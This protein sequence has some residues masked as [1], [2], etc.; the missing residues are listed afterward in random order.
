MYTVIHFRENL[1]QSTLLDAVQKLV[2]K[3]NT[4]FQHIPYCNLFGNHHLGY[5]TYILQPSWSCSHIL[6]IDIW[7]RCIMGLHKGTLTC[8][9]WCHCTRK[10]IEDMCDNLEYVKHLKRMN[11][12]YSISQLEDHTTGFKTSLLSYFFNI[13]KYHF[14]QPNKKINILINDLHIYRSTWVRQHWE[15]FCVQ[16]YWFHNYRCVVK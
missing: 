2:H 8:K 12:K 11:S 7:T 1:E 6:H 5:S 4:P 14:T 9:H 15:N 16:L 10:H 13:I 3:L